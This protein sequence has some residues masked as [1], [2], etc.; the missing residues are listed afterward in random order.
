MKMNLKDMTF[1]ISVRMDSIIRLENTL[2]SVQFLKRYFD[3]NV[4]LLEAS[5]YN[6]G[7]LERTVKREAHYIFIEDKD[8]IL[9]RSKYHNLLAKMVETPFMGIWD[10]DI[11]AP[12]DQVFRAVQELRDQNACLSYPYDGTCLDT[13]FIIR[14]QYLKRRDI[15]ILTKH[16]DKMKVMYGYQARGGA[17]FMPTDKYFEAG[18]ENENIYGWGQED[19]ELYKRCL[20]LGYEIKMVQGVLFHLTHPRGKN[21]WFR[22]QVQRIESQRQ[23]DITSA[24]SKDELRMDKRF[25]R[26]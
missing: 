10:S 9:Y 22:D 26:P 21:S 6:N 19:F 11:I 5:A 13:S 16:M 20:N 14:E 18:M 2:I 7:I 12:P 1:V 24:S 23:V 3:C 15:R 25:N 17:I 4:I 8:D